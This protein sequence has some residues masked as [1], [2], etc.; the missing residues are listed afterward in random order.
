MKLKRDWVLMWSK[1]LPTIFREDGTM[2]FFDNFCTSKALLCDLVE[3][4]IYGIGTAQ[5][6]RRHFPED[7]KKIQVQYKAIIII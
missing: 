1:N 2:S 5:T 7:L 6:N 4:K 3:V